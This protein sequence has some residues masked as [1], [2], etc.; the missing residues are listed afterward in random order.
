[1]V[2]PSALAVLRLM[3]SSNLVGR[4][5]GRSAGFWRDAPA[6]SFPHLPLLRDALFTTIRDRILLG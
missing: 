6:A 5:T 4:I 2:R 1:M 3:T